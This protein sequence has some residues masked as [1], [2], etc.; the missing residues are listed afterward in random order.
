MATTTAT[1]LIGSA[2]QNHSG[3]LPKWSIALTENSRPALI[4][5]SLIDDEQEQVIIPTIE[6]MIDDLYLVI[7]VCVLKLFEPAGS[8]N[9]PARN[10]L[11]D[12][13]SEDERK[14][15]YERS[16]K[17]LAG[18]KDKVVFHLLEDC[19]LLHQLDRIDGYPLDYEVTVPHIKREYDPWSK[20]VAVKKFSY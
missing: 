15:L 7:S 18:R 2:H 10:S 1:I 6:G 8:L 3:I 17:V 19:H 13:F 9:L 5:K 11:Y 12:I 4:V 20:Q 14:A 16:R